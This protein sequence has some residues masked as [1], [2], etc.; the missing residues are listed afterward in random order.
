MTLKCPPLLHPPPNLHRC[1]AEW[2]VLI[3]KADSLCPEPG[4]Q[5]PEG[6]SYY[7]GRETWP[8]LPGPR[9]WHLHH[10]S[11]PGSCDQGSLPWSPGQRHLDDARRASAAG[12]GPQDCGQ[13]ERARSERSA[14][15]GS[16]EGVPSAGG[17]RTERRLCFGRGNDSLWPPLN[18]NRYPVLSVYMTE[19][20]AHQLKLTLTN[21]TQLIFILNLKEKAVFD[22]IEIQC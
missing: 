13:W 11:I 4:N 12:G 5:Q 21:L 19:N 18:W 3:R 14:K 8:S 22:R 7:L 15:T 20:F 2:L 17:I 1:R 10:Q 9:D 16:G 6:E